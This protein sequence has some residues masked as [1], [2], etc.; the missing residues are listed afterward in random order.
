MGIV[1]VSVIVPV[2]NTGKYISKCLESLTNQTLKDIEIICVNDG[3]TDN[4]L[5]IL[6]AFADKDER[7]KII[8]Q[9]NKKQGAARNCGLQI[10]TGE[11]IGYIDSDDWVDLNYFENLYNAAQKHNSDIAFCT[12]VRTGGL[13]TTKKREHIICEHVAT[14]LQEKFDNSNV[15]T[16][17]CPTNKIYKKTLLKDNNIV[18][19]EDIYYEDKIFV[20]KAVY[21]A[22]S[23]VSVPETYY[24]YF[25]NPHSTVNTNIKKLCGNKNDKEIARKLVIEFL[26]ENKAQIR[27]KEIWTTLKSF[28]VLGI[29]IFQIKESLYTQ[30]YLLFSIFP[31]WEKRLCQ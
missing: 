30:R 25:R 27:D 10:A 9:E 21:Y 3:S 26:R 2:Y 4:S 31:I 15:F 6:K 28:N 12:V 5:E 11:Y 7:I 20:T 22:N 19:P 14:S 18:Y 29:P 23:I 24:Y 17:P 1:K 8:T 13:K 16:N